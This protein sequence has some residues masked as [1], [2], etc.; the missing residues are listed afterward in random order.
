MT[1]AK[2]RTPYNVGTA[3]TSL[4]RS[5]YLR[6]YFDNCHVHALKV[7]NQQGVDVLS[8]FTRF[9]KVEQTCVI[10]DARSVQAQLSAPSRGWQPRA[11]TLLSALANADDACDDAS[12]ARL[13]AARRPRPPLRALGHAE[14]TTSHHSS[15]G[16]RLNRSSQCR[17]YG[18]CREGSHRPRAC[19][20]LVSAWPSPMTRKFRAC[21][22]WRLFTPG[23]RRPRRVAARQT[24]APISPS[25]AVRW[26]FFPSSL[27]G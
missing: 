4:L 9:R 24:S 19:R 3:R 17:G 10:V 23:K 27:L 8:L 6:R 5:A 25:F 13:T 14:Y 7:G 22:R 20:Q 11:F 21:L 26:H 12:A 1:G 16:R 15:I 18:S 2:Y